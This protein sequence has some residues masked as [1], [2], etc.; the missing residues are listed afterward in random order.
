M[1]GDETVPQANFGELQGQRV[2]CD[3]RAMGFIDGRL[4]VETM[5]ILV[6]SLGKGSSAHFPICVD[7]WAVAN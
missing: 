6:K 3:R 4:S 1:L 7:A 5:Q 2:G